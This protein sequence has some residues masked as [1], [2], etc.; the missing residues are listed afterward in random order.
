MREKGK[1]RIVMA[2]ELHEVGFKS[3]E[4]RMEKT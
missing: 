3:E 2:F 1:V 4:A